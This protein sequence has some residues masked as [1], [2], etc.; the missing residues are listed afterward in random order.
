MAVTKLIRWSIRAK[1]TQ[2]HVTQD[3]FRT[4][5]NKDIPNNGEHD[6]REIHSVNDLPK[7]TCKPC[8]HRMVGSLTIS[9]I[10]R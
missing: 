7:G 6:T 9:V 5:C 10:T 1:W 2:Y 4:L 3:G 8:A